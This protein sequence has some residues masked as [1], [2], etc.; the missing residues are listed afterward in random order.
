VNQNVLC[1]YR[2]SSEWTDSAALLRQLDIKLMSSGQ[3]DRLD[4]AVPPAVCRKRRWSAPPDC[5][6]A[7]SATPTTT[8]HHHANA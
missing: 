7:T 5:A 1:V 2:E 3:D 6:T 4:A 8:T